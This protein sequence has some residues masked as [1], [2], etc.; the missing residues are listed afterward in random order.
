MARKKKFNPLLVIIPAVIVI[1]A[2]LLIVLLAPKKEPEKNIR[3]L[4][5]SSARVPYYYVNEEENRLIRSSQ[6]LQRGTPVNDLNKSYTENGI[7]YAVIEYN[8]ENYYISSSSMV[9]D[10]EDVIQETEV[11]VRTSATIYEN[12]TGPEIASFAKKGSCLFPNPF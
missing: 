1:A 2:V 5:S 10:P 3:Y 4:A 11:W 7:E 6:M 9:D 8:G 12:E